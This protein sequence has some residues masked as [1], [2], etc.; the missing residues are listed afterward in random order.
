M[1]SI[2][3]KQLILISVIAAVFA[4]L[5]MFTPMAAAEVTLSTPQ[6]TSVEPGVVSNQNTAVDLI[7]KGSGFQPDRIVML[8]KSGEEPRPGI[9]TEMDWNGTTIYCNVWVYGMAAGDWDVEVTNPDGGSCALSGAVT[10][11]DIDYETVY[12]GT[13][14]C[15]DSMEVFND[16]LYAG[17]QG[18]NG[19]QLMRSGDGNSWSTV[20]ANG[21]GDSNN[22]SVLS[23]QV[24][25]GALYAG[26][27]NDN[28]CK[29]YRTTNGTNFTQVNVTGF[30]DTG[31]DMASSM[32]SFNGNLYVGTYNRYGCE[33]WRSSNG[34]DWSLVGNTGFGAGG[35]NS[36]AKS[37]LVF[38]NR[39]YIATD[40]AVFRSATGTSWARVSSFAEGD[41]PMGDYMEIFEDEIYVGTGISYAGTCRLYRSSDGIIWKVA[42]EFDFGYDWNN[43]ISI[44]SLSVFGDLLCPYVTWSRTFSSGVPGTIPYVVSDRHFMLSN[45]GS[46]FSEL[47]PKIAYFY[48]R[49][50]FKGQLYLGHRNSIARLVGLLRPKVTSIIPSSGFNTGSVNVTIRGSDFQ[51]GATAK[52]TLA[53]QNDINGS[54]VNVVNSSTIT[55]AFNIKGAAGG[56]WNVVVTNPDGAEGS[57]P[58]GFKVTPCGTG[59]GM[60]VLALG[61]LLGLISAGEAV[62]RRR[63]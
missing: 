61:L 13:F 9:V 32:A 7:I 42:K 59:G 49:C 28:G 1:D 48:S 5:L 36:T 57:L 29:I 11:F 53:G 24:F 62:R 51:S 55:C 46:S 52:L 15:V 35:S 40:T 38:K 3:T 34:V 30:G 12:E 16:Y 17:T 14:L 10:I 25:N 6:I 4:A 26:T 41:C 27:R 19:C 60:A 50:L 22:T 43:Y 44:N 56:N 33:I 31:N 58:A 20:V 39:L 45:D 63:R 47:S 2:R 8:S 54:N 21:F 23:M 37:M 18:S